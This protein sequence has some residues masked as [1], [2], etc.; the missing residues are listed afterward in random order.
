MGFWTVTKVKMVAATQDGL[1]LPL[2]KT[3]AVLERVVLVPVGVTTMVTVALAP[4]ARLPSA[5]VTVLADS[6]Q[7]PWVADAEPKVTPA[8]S[9]S[10]IV[11]V[12]V[13]PVLVATI[14]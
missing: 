4:P 8:G 13:A 9:G 14:V 6:V 5:Q 11:T 10:T 2:R 3:D 7:V 1:V 12:A